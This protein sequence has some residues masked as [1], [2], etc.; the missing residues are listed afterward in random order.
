MTDAP[1]EGYGIVQTETTSGECRREVSKGGHQVWAV[2][3]REA[4][5]Q[6]EEEVEM[7][8][9]EDDEVV[10]PPA[11]IPGFLELYS[12]AETLTGDVR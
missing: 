8:G 5:G 1:E 9:Q 6:I 10:R 2:R 11:G 7:A 12:G 3:A 4:F